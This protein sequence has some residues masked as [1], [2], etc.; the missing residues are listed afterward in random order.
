MSSIN[1]FTASLASLPKLDAVKHPPLTPPVKGPDGD[2]HLTATG[3]SDESSF[4]QQAEIHHLGTHQLPDLDGFTKFSAR[5]KHYLQGPDFPLYGEGDFSGR[6]IDGT[7]GS[8]KIQV[9]YEPTTGGAYVTRSVMTQN[10]FGDWIDTGKR[11]TSYLNAEEAKS[12]F[13]RGNEGNDTIEVD[14]RFPYPVRISGGAGDDYMAGGAG[15]DFFSGGPG[16]DILY[17]NAGFDRY[18]SRDARDYIYLGADQGGAVEDNP[19]P[20]PVLH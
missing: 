5:M 15:A 18:D 3:P 14:P 4:T 19:P 10:S 12:L 16:D 9:R 8:D 7:S 6:L 11:T 2:P 1:K 17:G 20:P 13:I